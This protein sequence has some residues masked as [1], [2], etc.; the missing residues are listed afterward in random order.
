MEK[1]R[2][3][4]WEM[5]LVQDMELWEVILMSVNMENFLS[6]L[7]VQLWESHLVHTME[8]Q[9]VLLMS[10]QLGMY[11]KTLRAVQERCTSGSSGIYPV[12]GRVGTW[13]WW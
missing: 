11:L 4:H 6:I 9:E 12:R 8:M 7:R 10:Y 5:I 1:F 3:I 2:D 13:T